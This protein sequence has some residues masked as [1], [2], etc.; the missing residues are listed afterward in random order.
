MYR[1]AAIVRS[2]GSVK[3][4]RFE[5]KLLNELQRP[6]EE[7]ET[8][9][10][11]GRMRVMHMPFAFSAC[12]AY[13]MTSGDGIVLGTLFAR[14]RRTYGR[15]PL[16]EL[17]A[18]LAQHAR[19]TGGRSLASDLWG[20]YVAFIEIE[21][22]ERHLVLRDP[23][24]QLACYQTRLGELLLYVSDVALLARSSFFRP[25]LD[26]R[27]L[28]AEIMVPELATSRT[29]LRRVREV[30][31]GEGDAISDSRV[32]PRAYWSPAS[33]AQREEPADFSRAA[34]A[35]RETV[36]SCVQAW[37]SCYRSLIH[38]LSGGLDSSIVL[39]CLSS[40]PSPPEI[41]CVN[42]HSRGAESD[43]RE[44]ARIAAEWGGCELITL[45]MPR[46]SSLSP[47]LRSHPLTATPSPIL[48][49]IQ[50]KAREQTLA[51]ERG[52]QAFTSGLAGDHL[53]YQMK[54][55]LVAAD[56]A[57]RK[58]L[59]GLRYQGLRETAVWCG[60]SVWSILAMAVRHGLFRR[61]WSQ[62]P[63]YDAAEFPCL[64]TAIR[65][66]LTPSVVEHPWDRDGAAVAPGKA[67]QIHLLSKLFRR[68]EISPRSYAGD[69]VHPLLSQPIMELALAIPSDVL[70]QGGANRAL[71]RAAFAPLVPAPIIART[72]K[73]G[74]TG[75]FVR[76]VLDNLDEVRDFLC[77]GRLV[78]EAIADRKELESYL[79]PARLNR[80]GEIVTTLKLL[81][82]EAWARSWMDEAEQGSR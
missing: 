57:R 37:G 53:F 49:G 22:G 40:A 73:G 4:D 61:R 75:Y 42:H 36:E 48:L 12:R 62:G 63:Q 47:L 51:V 82:A 59:T 79:M 74:T 43:E 60:E 66:S 13:R 69:I 70:T 33:F 25:C 32:A 67:F 29:G 68:Q 44:Y 2:P 5:Q 50:G 1:F 52:A 16:A 11:R 30:L 18:D 24:G 81:A 27:Y 14:D 39:A 26:K 10:D 80:A 41:L 76:L 34:D 38:D 20:R 31:P 72:T 17:P 6:G 55:P 64:D 71:A 77:S 58:G 65:G 54:T 21:D 78:S 7:W 9:L 35:L 23:S 45:E 19:E 28:A 56:A 46:S 3:S 15:G 8:L